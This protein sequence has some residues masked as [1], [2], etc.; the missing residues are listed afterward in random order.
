MSELF[1]KAHVFIKEAY[2][3]QLLEIPLAE[4]ILCH[5]QILIIRKI[6]FNSIYV[7]RSRKYILHS[8]IQCTENVEQ[9]IIHNWEIGSTYIIFG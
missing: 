4:N 8:A 7:S 2:E 1:G 3:S 6:S 5:N 9:Y